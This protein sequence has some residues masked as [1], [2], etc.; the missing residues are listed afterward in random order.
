MCYV[1]KFYNSQCWWICILIKEV[2][3]LQFTYENLSYI[4]IQLNIKNMGAFESFLVE[5]QYCEFQNSKLIV[6]L[7]IQLIINGR[8]SLNIQLISETLLS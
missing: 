6:L 2:Y 1:I 4:T 5:I 8:D 3:G 7:D